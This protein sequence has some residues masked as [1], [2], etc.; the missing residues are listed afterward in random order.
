MRS[1][2]PALSHQLTLSSSLLALCPSAL[3]LY[4]GK[5]TQLQLRCVAELGR[6]A[7]Y[8][9]LNDD[10]VNVRVDFPRGVLGGT[11]GEGG[12]GENRERWRRGW[13]WQWRGEGGGTG[14]TAAMVGGGGDGGGG[15][16]GGGLEGRC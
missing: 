15:D 7:R 11:R 1:R 9:E 12:G 3:T 2:S 13:R 14:E 5:R 10:G 16:G 4:L 6:P 8:R